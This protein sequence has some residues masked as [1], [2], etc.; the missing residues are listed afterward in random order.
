MC[1]L[2]E[3]SHRFVSSTRITSGASF[4]E[5]TD[6]THAHIHSHLQESEVSCAGDSISAGISFGVHTHMHMYMYVYITR[7]HTDTN[8]YNLQESN[9]DVRSPVVVTQ[10]LLVSLFQYPLAVASRKLVRFMY[11]HL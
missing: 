6:R 10:S 9:S 3:P 8:I 1:V 11:M 5:Y 2:V 7:T 4:R